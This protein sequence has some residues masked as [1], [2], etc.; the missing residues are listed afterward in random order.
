MRIEIG[1]MHVAAFC[2]I[3][4]YRDDWGPA[5]EKSRNNKRRS[6]NPHQDTETVQQINNMCETD[7]AALR[8][9]RYNARAAFEHCLIPRLAVCRTWSIEAGKWMGETRFRRF[10]RP[11]QRAPRTIYHGINLSFRQATSTYPVFFASSVSAAFRTP[12][13]FSLDDSLALSSLRCLFSSCFFFLIKSR[14]R[15]SYWKFGC[16]NLYPF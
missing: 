7:K 2:V 6:K 11:I 9:N 12:S 4:D 8:N 14:W 5:S 10:W 13:G 15:F 3:N 1:A 16:A